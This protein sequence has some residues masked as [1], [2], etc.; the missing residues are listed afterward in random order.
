[1]ERERECGKPW[2][3]LT[4]SYYPNTTLLS[5][6]HNSLVIH[7][8]PHIH[9]HITPHTHHMHTLMTY[10]PHTQTHKHTNTGSH[11]WHPPRPS[12]HAYQWH[13]PLIHCHTTWCILQGNGYSHSSLPVCIS[14]GAPCVYISHCCCDTTV[15]VWGCWWGEGV[16]VW[17]VGVFVGVIVNNTCMHTTY[18]THTYNAYAHVH[19][20]IHHLHIHT[21]TCMQ[22]A[23]SPPPKT[24]GAC[25]SKGVPYLMHWHHAA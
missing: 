13:T 7:L 22:S 15:G 6:H 2:H 8:H 25:C 20:R 19:I 17:V 5:P 1:M 23:S 12:R 4:C 10:P 16:Y 24:T 11:L 3:D 9:T 14:D 21:Y 18:D